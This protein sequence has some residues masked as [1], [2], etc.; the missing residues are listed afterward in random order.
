M[1]YIFLYRRVAVEIDAILKSLDEMNRDLVFYEFD[2]LMSSEANWI[3]RVENYSSQEILRCID[4]IGKKMI[5]YS[6][7]VNLEVIFLLT[8]S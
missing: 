2:E 7:R 3:L 8:V 5:N 1:G 4:K 6:L